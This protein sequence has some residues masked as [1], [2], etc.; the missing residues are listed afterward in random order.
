MDIATHH[1]PSNEHAPNRRPANA[2]PMQLARLLSDQITP[3]QRFILGLAGP[4]GTGKSTFAERLAV[5]LHPFSCAVVPLDGFHLGSKIVNGTPLQQRRGAIDTFDAAGYAALLKRLHTRDEAVVY[6]PFYDREIEE[7]IAGSIAVDQATQIVITEGNYLLVDHGDWARARALMN[8][9]W[10]VD[11]EHALRIERLTARHIQ[12]G[13]TPDA[14]HAWVQTSDE[15]NAAVVLST[16]KHA[17][18]VVTWN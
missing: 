2:D 16:K 5:A 13:K 14:A 1:H 4:P 11:T 18:L 17:G 12:F 7:P 6:A 10:F 8:Q 3:D 15:A 9:V